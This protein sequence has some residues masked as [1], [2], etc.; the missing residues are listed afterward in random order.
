M[1]QRAECMVGHTGPRG[2]GGGTGGAEEETE[3]GKRRKM[4]D[5]AEEITL[6]R[7]PPATNA[8]KQGPHKGL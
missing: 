4:E 7:V 5:N 8:S 1:A 2:G 6:A 3:R